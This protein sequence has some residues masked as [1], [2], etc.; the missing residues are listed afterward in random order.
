MGNVLRPYRPLHLVTQQIY[1][2]LVDVPLPIRE[3]EREGDEI[4]SKREREC[5]CLP[6]QVA[7]Y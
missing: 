4:R 5:V 3:R 2:Y 6:L 1:Q 7:F